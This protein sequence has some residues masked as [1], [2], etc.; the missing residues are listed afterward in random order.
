MQTSPSL[1]QWLEHCLEQRPIR[2]VFVCG[3]QL[4]PPL[5]SHVVTFPRLE[6]PLKGHYEN[7]IEQDN[8]AATV[9]LRPGTALFAAPN[10]WNLPTWRRNVELLSML[11]GKKHIG[12]SHVIGTGLNRPQITAQK[13]SAYFPM[14]G[15]LP[16][17]LDAMVELQVAGKPQAA[18]TH[19]ALALVHCVRELFQ[20]PEAQIINRAQSLLGAVCV[21]LQNQYQHD[22]SRDIV[23]RQFNISPNHLSRLFQTHGSMTFSNYLTH[24]RI[25]RSKFLLCNYDLKLDDIAAR[26]G[27]RDTPYFCRVFKRISKVTPAEYRTTHRARSKQT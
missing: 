25:N 26:C 8:R 10:C 14:T 18:F 3:R 13:F 16:S 2:E 20:H 19:L 21:Y 23:A 1:D 11:F 12:I 24:V 15:P 5:F 22:V 4:H 27:F 17:I 6:I 7:E 9:A